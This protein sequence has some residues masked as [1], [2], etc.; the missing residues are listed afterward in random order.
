MARRLSGPEHVEVAQECLSEMVAA[1]RAGD[2]SKL[3][4]L[5][6]A[7]QAHMAMAGL[8]WTLPMAPPEQLAGRQG[9]RWLAAAGVEVPR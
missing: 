2:W 7:T 8:A 1:R 3:H 9:R 6:A 4:A 5:A